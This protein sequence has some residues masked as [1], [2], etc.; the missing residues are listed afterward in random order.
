L[1]DDRKVEI[2]FEAKGDQ[3]LITQRFEAE[4]TNPR[5]LQQG[6]WQAILNNF[7]KYAAA[8]QGSISK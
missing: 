8:Q 6:G 2:E 4:G 5:D 3:T 7:A 1:E